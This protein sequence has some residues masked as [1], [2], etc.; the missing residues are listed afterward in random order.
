MTNEKEQKNVIRVGSRASRLAVLQSEIVMRQIE[1]ACPDVK[2]ELVTMK[3][4]G[5]RILDKTL[6]QIGGKGLF[7]KELD[8]ALRAGEVD[9]TVHSLKDLP[10]VIPEDLPLAAFSNREDPRDVLVLPAGKTEIDMSLPVGTSSLRR[11]LQIKELIPGVT[12]APIRGNVETRLRKLDEGQ[13]SALVLA[14]AGLKRLGLEGRIS[15]YFS[16]EEMI[17]AA[18]QGVL[19]I[20]TR[21]GADAALIGRISD[22]DAGR[23]ALAE[24]AYVKAI[25]ADCGSP[26]TAFAQISGDQIKIMGLRY[27]AERDHIIRDC[28]SGPASGAEELGRE[29]AHR[30]IKK[31]KVWLVGAGPGEMSLITLKGR[32]VLAEAD[33]VV[34][35][36]LVRGGMMS[37]IPDGA[38]KIY[39]G[40][41]AGNHSMSQ[42]DINS[43]L[44][45]KALEGKNVVRLKGGDPFLFGRGG[46]ELELL[47]QNGID[48][49]IVPGVT[50]AFAAPAYAGIPVT[51]RDFCRGVSVI[52]GHR[53]SN[54][55]L[56][57]NFK[58][59][60]ETGNTL[61]FLMGMS[62]KEIIANGLLDAGMPGDTAAAII[63]KGTTSSQRV[64]TTDLAHLVETAETANAAAPAV[65]VI[66]SAAGL[67][68]RL[69]W[70]G[71]LPLDGVRAVVTRPKELS[72][73]LASMLRKRGAEV[74]EVPVIDIEPVSDNDRLEAAIGKMA[75]G[76]YN[77][78]VLTSPS[79]VRVFFDELMKTADARALSGCRIASI[80]KGT[81]AELLKRG[82][83]ADM[84][85]SRYDG[86][87]LGVELSRLLERGDHVLIPRAKIGNKALVEELSKAEDVVIDDIA[88][89]DTVYRPADWFDASKE[90]TDPDTFALFTSA[91]GVRGFVSAYPDM[92]HSEVK[93]VCIGEMTAAEAGK[94]G[95]KVWVS[96][97][98][99][100]VSLADRLQEASEELAALVD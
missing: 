12:T 61:V 95:M 35:D 10:G 64:L 76:Y 98:A 90:L 68:E 60:A 8:E 39:A 25:G 26:D 23:C 13:Y 72:S 42:E 51:H 7:V 40:K 57:L 63:E 78:V 71:N 22:H 73:G 20:Q 36:A 41:R 99:T 15:R 37:L 21:A 18:C 75:D 66:G 81:E 80:G 45:E 62:T 44:L 38:E 55:T 96:E 77:W 79:G 6:D 97:E 17:P 100:L 9:L 86:R 87:T 74:L 24:R 16:P 65:I 33:V 92:D 84:V 30:M 54:G 29:L 52:T 3:T 19:G 31:G 11:S 48:F 59:L 4:T 83:H 94:H 2:V 82:V 14:A 43:L 56:D 91:S 93:A 53:R 47:V 34:Y 50:S 28:I 89:Y 88:T 46:E 5:D 69:G 1:K 70:R 58:A 27:D 85:P 32:D 49:E 67:A